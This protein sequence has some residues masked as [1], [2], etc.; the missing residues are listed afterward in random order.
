LS[1]AEYLEKV[2][3]IM[4]SVRNRTGDDVPDKLEHR[5]VAKAFYGL[6]YE[7][8]NKF[9]CGEHDPREFSADV[10]L[11]IDDIV[12]DCLIVDW[13]NNKDIQNTMLNKIEEYLYTVKDQYGIELSF[14]DIDTIMRQSLNVAKTRYAKC[15]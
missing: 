13:I 12:Q 8:I 1:D 4:N 3:E 5:E 14:D 2:T 15:E 6:V 11:M 10:G 7:V 9:E